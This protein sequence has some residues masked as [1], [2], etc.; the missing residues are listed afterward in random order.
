MK[1]FLS[2]RA[3]PDPFQMTV[4][5]HLDAS[6]LEQV[7]EGGH[8]LAAVP[9][10]GADGGNQFAERMACPVEFAVGVEALRFHKSFDRGPRRT[11]KK[12][13]VCLEVFRARFQADR[14]WPAGHDETA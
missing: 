3:N 11:F 14:E 10:G 9:G 2:L 7:D 1:K 6:G 8:G 5:A 12:S 13:N 4:I